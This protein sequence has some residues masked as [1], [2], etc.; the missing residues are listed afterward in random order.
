MTIDGPT[1][2]RC[3]DVQQTD[4]RLITTVCCELVYGHV[5]RGGCLPAKPVSTSSRVGFQYMSSASTYY[6]VVTYSNRLQHCTEH[7]KL[8]TFCSVCIN[9]IYAYQNLY[10]TVNSFLAA[11][12]STRGSMC[13]VQ[14]QT[15]PPC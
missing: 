2:G 13:N 9:I 6:R 11:Y 12:C 10:W 14:K 8:N 15:F 3:S 5:I 1:A 7:V 4:G